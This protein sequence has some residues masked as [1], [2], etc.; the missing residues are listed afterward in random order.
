MNN[1][2][3]LDGR[4]QMADVATHIR[5]FDKHPS[6]DLV[7]KRALTITAM[8]ENFLKLKSYV[9]YFQLTEDIAR[10]LE[11]KEFRVPDARSVEVEEHIHAQSPAFTREGQDLQILTCLMLAMLNAIKNAEPAA[12]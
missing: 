11:T 6:D 8:A 7:S 4:R 5:I 1:L 2:I 3:P 12:T 9:D 10:A